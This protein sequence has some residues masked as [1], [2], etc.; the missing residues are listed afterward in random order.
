MLAS[1]RRFRD[2]TVRIHTNAGTSVE[3]V[4][5]SVSVDYLILRGASDVRPEG[6]V[7]L[8]G[9]ALVPRDSIDYLQAL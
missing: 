7:E 1:Y 3:G 4:L 2:R 9:E 8:E 6:S 5:E